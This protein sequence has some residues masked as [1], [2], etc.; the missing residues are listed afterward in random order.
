MTSGGWKD[1]MFPWRRLRK[2]GILGMNERNADFVLP[3]NPRSLYQLVDDKRRT[4]ALAIEF[5]IPVP[6]LYAVVEIEHQI[7]NL[8]RL[9]APYDEFV[10]KPAHGSGGEGILVVESR[11]DGRYRRTSGLILTEEDLGHHI[12]NILSGMYSLGGIPD[13]ALIEYRVNFNPLF[14]EVSYLGVPDIR[15]VV[16]RGVP[17]MAMIRAPTRLSD[18]KANLHQGAVGVG[19][20]MITGRTYNG[21]WRECRVEEH[22]DTGGELAGICVPHWDDILTMAARCNDMVGMGYIGVDIV[23]DRDLGPLMLELNARPGLSIQLAARTGLLPRLRYLEG[24]RHIPRDV[25]ERVAL[26]KTVANRC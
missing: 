17:V 25:P 16:F 26:A 5:G 6:R 10:V 19:V 22:P 24:M 4:K 2:L 1:R 12:S 18:G 8:P 14:A 11:S 9:L 21:I 20:D 23:L 15:I 7:E 3:Y 13:C